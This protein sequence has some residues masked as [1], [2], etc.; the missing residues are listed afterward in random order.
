MG[1]CLRQSKPFHRIHWIKKDYNEQAIKM[2]KFNLEG[3]V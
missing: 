3:I 2:V 1:F